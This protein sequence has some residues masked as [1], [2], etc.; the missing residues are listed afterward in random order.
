MNHLQ[1]GKVLFLIFHVITLVVVDSITKN[2][3]RSGYILFPQRLVLAAFLANV[4]TVANQSQSRF[5]AGVCRQC[6]NNISK[7]AKDL[8][9]QAH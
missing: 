4:H 9:L 3:C 1:Q 2:V 8:C 5:L 6:V 7:V